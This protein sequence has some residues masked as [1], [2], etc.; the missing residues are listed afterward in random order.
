MK[1]SQPKS[2]SYPCQSEQSVVKNLFNPSK[3]IHV[4]NPTRQAFSQKLE[5]EL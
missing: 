4:E 5:S 3:E 1:I 2:S